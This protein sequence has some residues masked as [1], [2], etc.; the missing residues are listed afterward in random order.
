MQCPYLNDREPEGSLQPHSEINKHI[1]LLEKQA[2]ERS[3]LGLPPPERR[4]RLTHEVQF[5]Q[6]G[7]EII[8]GWALVDN[9]EREHEP[10]IKSDPDQPEIKTEPDQ[11]EIKTKPDQPEIKQEPRVN[12]EDDD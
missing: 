9:A 12:Q 10:E 3:G 6:R 4:E 1:Q 7:G 8:F 5:R 11:S 2:A